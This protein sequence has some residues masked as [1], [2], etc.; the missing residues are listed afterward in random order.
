M[1]WCNG[2]TVFEASTSIHYHYSHLHYHYSHLQNHKSEESDDK[3]KKKKEVRQA[4]HRCQGAECC[5]QHA[6]PDHH[7][8]IGVK[9]HVHWKKDIEAVTRSALNALNSMWTGLRNW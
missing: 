1:I 3:R 8:A 2:S 9:A 4:Q 6:A 7:M 5:A